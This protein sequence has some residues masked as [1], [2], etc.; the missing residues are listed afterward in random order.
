MSCEYQKYTDNKLDFGVISPNT[1]YRRLILIVENSLDS[2]RDR[3]GGVRFE[4]RKRFKEERVEER[5]R[6]K[7]ERGHR[8]R[9]G[10]NPQL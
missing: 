5:K 1:I 7:E 8:C 3:G 6:K 2:R 10:T 9:S 4:Q